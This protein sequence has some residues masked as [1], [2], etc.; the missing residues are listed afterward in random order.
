MDKKSP[1][2]STGGIVPLAVFFVTCF[3]A[4]LW[5]Y[6]GYRIA[7]Q[8]NRN[9]YLW[10][11]AALLL[12]LLAILI[13]Y[14]LPKRIQTKSIQPPSQPVAINDIELPGLWYYLNEKRETLGPYSP[15]EFRKAFKEGAFHT[16]SYVWNEDFNDWKKV[17][18]D[19]S[20][21]EMLEKRS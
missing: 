8:Q 9:P 21:I 16:K 2:L 15:Q 12:G 20:L 17:E 1:V 3:I 10:A 18:E 5:T 7:L 11:A 19:K 4:C 13:L 6:I 14:M